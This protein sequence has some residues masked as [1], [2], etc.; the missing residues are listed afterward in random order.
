MSIKTSDMQP[1]L[2]SN[3]QARQ[4]VTEVVLGGDH[5]KQRSYAIEIAH[6]GN[7]S[8]G[9]NEHTLDC[10]RARVREWRAGCGK[11]NGHCMHRPTDAVI[12]EGAHERCY[13]PIWTKHYSR[14]WKLVAAPAWPS[15]TSLT[16]PLLQ[17]CLAG[18]M[19][20]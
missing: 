12:N 11:C 18:L 15:L 14:I 7:E 3:Y 2:T 1:K 19:N 8:R 9:E 5:C 4:M 13:C 10:M 16:R 6:F 20:E 17:C